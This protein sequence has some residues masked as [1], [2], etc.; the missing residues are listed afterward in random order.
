LRTFGHKKP[1]RDEAGEIV[2]SKDAPVRVRTVD[3]LGGAFGPDRDKRLVVSLEDRDQ[4]VMRPERTGRKL[5]ASAVD[6]YR[7]L[8]GC[9]A[10]R[11]VLE[12]ARAK[13]SKKAERLAA[14][15]EQRWVKRGC[16]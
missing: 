10:N 15:R 12:R 1:V 7:W 5:Q 14:Q 4:I 16:K 3:T 6:V 8:I 9:E 13:K 2:G 11:K